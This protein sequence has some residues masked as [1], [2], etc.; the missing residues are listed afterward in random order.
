MLSA[1]T[2]APPPMPPSL[3]TPPSLP[4]PLPRTP[5][6]FSSESA[7]ALA[8]KS[9]KENDQQRNTHMDRS[10]MREAINS[11]GPPI[12]RSSFSMMMV[13]GILTAMGVMALFFAVV[14]TLFITILFPG[15]E[16]TIDGIPIAS[17][18]NGAA[19]VVFIVVGI[20]VL[21]GNLG[22]T[23]RLRTAWENGWVE[24]RPALIGELMHKRVVRF[25]EGSDDHYYTAPVLILQPDGTLT[26]AVTEEFRLPDPNWL[27]IRG[28]KLAGVGYR[29]IVDLNLNN[30]WG[31]VGY[32]VDTGIPKPELENGLRKKNI[33]AALAFAEQNWVKP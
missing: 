16:G 30:G 29:A 22:R 21:R 26:E 31:V 25:S 20:L 6:K 13:G 17:L 5:L 2:H 7:E 1:M 27:Q 11:S 14:H 3:P 10:G 32:R 24:Y 12:G 23:T 18:I 33:E 4:V 19:A 15:A 9:M 8:P 28:R